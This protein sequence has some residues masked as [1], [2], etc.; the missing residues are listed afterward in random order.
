MLYYSHAPDGLEN[1]EPGDQIDDMLVVGAQRILDKCILCAVDNTP[2]QV[3]VIGHVGV[4][5]V[6]TGDLGFMYH[7]TDPREAALCFQSLHG[8]LYAHRN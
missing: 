8:V 4:L 7:T 3:P 1:I 2:N 6:Q 5:D